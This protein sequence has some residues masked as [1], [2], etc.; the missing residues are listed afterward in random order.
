MT[1]TAVFQ[2]IVWAIKPPAIVFVVGMSIL[3]F[4]AGVSQMPLI[5]LY[6]DAA[7]YGEWKTGVNCRAFV[8]SMY[9]IPLKLG[10]L[11]KGVV[12]SVILAAIHYDASLPPA[13]FKNAFYNGYLLLMA[14]LN[15]IAVLILVAGFKLTEDQVTQMALEIQERNQAKVDAAEQ[16]A[17]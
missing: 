13:T 12:I 14:I 6:S 4:A 17:E 1:I 2:L 3:A 9:N 15:L 7:T 10:L 5:A 11:I 8:M 16:A